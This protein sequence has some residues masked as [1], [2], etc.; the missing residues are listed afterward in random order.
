MRQV[1]VNQWEVGWQCP[2]FSE[3][4]DTPCAQAGANPFPGR[5]TRRFVARDVQR[6][7]GKTV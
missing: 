3:K 5:R 6:E 7:A 1:L 4:H 2:N